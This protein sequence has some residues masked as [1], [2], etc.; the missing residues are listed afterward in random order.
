MNDAQLQNVV[1]Q[2]LLRNESIRRGDLQTRSHSGR[3]LKGDT[4]RHEAVG[5]SRIVLEA[6]V[7]TIMDLED[8]VAAVDAEDKV[9]IY[10]NFLARSGKPNG[11][12]LPQSASPGAGQFD[13][14]LAVICG[15]I[16][17]GRNPA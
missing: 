7:T 15:P 16:G 8:S 14:A 4:R 5:A 6:A 17:F 10:R 1:V 2:L 12:R 13:Y 11:P 3:I 9:A